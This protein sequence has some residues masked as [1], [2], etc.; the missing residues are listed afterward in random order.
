[1]RGWQIPPQPS[2][3]VIKKGTWVVEVWL[4]SFLTLALN[5]GEWSALRP[6]R[7][8]PGKGQRYALTRRMGGPRAGLD[9]WTGVVIMLCIRIGVHFVVRA[10]VLVA[11][12]LRNEL[13]NSF[14][15]ISVNVTCLPFTL[16]TQLIRTCGRQCKR[17][18]CERYWCHWD[19][20]RIRKIWVVTGFRKKM[21]YRFCTP[22]FK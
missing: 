11:C 15:R 3:L 8:F 14:M 12:V 22:S 19:P 5:G 6:G 18:K 16:F 9:V 1:M 2:C 7:L 17:L 4:Y 13:W 21:D 10:C 20:R